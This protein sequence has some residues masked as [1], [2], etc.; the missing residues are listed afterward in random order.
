MAL[1][2]LFGYGLCAV[3]ITAGGFIPSMPAVEAAVGFLVAF[4]AV[5]MISREVARPRL[6]SGSAAAVLVLLG[7]VAWL[8]PQG[9]AAW[10]LLGLGIFTLGFARIAAAGRLPVLVSAALFGFVDGCVLPGDFA[11]LQLQGQNPALPLWA[12]NAGAW[13]T[14]TFLLAATAAAAAMLQRQKLRLPQPLLQDL[15]ATA[16]AGVGTFWLVAA[17]TPT[18]SHA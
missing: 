15:A 2:L 3:V 18:L 11:S 9:R 5:P 8:G 16:L 13:F 10:L 6:V 12:F 7:A 17:I 4:L 1:A 14:A